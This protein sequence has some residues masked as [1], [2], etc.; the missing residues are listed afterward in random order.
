[1]PSCINCGFFKNTNNQIQHGQRK[2]E[3]VLEKKYQV[4]ADTPFHL[5]LI[6][7]CS[8]YP[9]CRPTKSNQN[10]RIQTRFLVCPARINLCIC[11]NHFCLR[12]SD[13]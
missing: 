1:M 4:P 6:F 3:D 5:V 12:L 11:D 8:W 2:N 10:W 9:A 7:I 13:E